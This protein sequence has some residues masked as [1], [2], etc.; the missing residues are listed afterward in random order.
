MDELNNVNASASGKITLADVENLP[1][2]ID[3]E[4]AR[5]LLG[6]G[7]STFYALVRQG[8]IPGAFRLGSKLVRINTRALLAG[9]TAHRDSSD[10][11]SD[12]TIGGR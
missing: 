3:Q 6:I 9:L 4:T 1:A 8:R 11:S 5:R 10:E 2:V 7:R 12:E